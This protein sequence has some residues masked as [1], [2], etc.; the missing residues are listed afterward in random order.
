MFT[1]QELI[2][3]SVLIVLAACWLLTICEIKYNR[4]K[5]P[6]PIFR[7]KNNDDFIKKVEGFKL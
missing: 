5:E 7:A 2:V 3:I 4:K 6:Q 1:I